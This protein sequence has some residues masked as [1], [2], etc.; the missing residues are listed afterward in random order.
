MF[1]QVTNEDC[2]IL[3]TEQRQGAGK[4]KQNNVTLKYSL[5]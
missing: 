5:Y 1:I 2:D 3:Y 4:F